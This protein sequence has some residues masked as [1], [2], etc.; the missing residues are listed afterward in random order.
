MIKK[1]EKLSEKC[2]LIGIASFG[3]E[4][5]LGQIKFNKQ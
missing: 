4:E 1:L 5:V 3:K 2:W